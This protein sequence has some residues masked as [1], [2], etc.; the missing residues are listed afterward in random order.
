MTVGKRLICGHI[1]HEDCLRSGPF[2]NSFREWIK[3][4][5]ICPTCRRTIEYREGVE[6]PEDPQQEQE[7]IDKLAPGKEVPPKAGDNV[8]A[9]AFSLPRE[10]AD[11]DS[12]AAERRRLEIEATNRRILTTEDATHKKEEEQKHN[13]H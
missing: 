9:V 3:T 1:F 7:R 13:E 8:G 4:H 6:M 12:V 10:A 5:A 11:R 2:H